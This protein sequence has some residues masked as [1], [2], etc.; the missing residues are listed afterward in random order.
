M[1]AVTTVQPE[2]ITGGEPLAV[3]LGIT[4]RQLDYW[5]LQGHLRPLD[6]Q[7]GTG[8]AREWPES[9]LIIARRMGRLT[10]AGL[11]LSFAAAMARES[12]PA[13]RLAEGIT[14]TVTEETT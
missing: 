4:Y 11:P 12:W 6:P 8:N 9:E 3:S 7:P 2:T 1:A 10:A 5:V 13:G 14:V